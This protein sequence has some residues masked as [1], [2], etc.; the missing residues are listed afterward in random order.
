MAAFRRVLAAEE[1]LAAI[2]PRKRIFFAVERRKLQ[3]STRVEAWVGV[4]VIFLA[5]GFWWRRW[6][7]LPAAVRSVGGVVLGSVVLPRW[8][9]ALTLLGL[10]ADEGEV[11]CT[12]L[13]RTLERCGLKGE[14]LLRK[15]GELRRHGRERRSS[16]L[17][18]KLFT[19]AARSRR[20]A[21]M[22]AISVEMED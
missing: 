16:N 9:F 19:V 10:Q 12:D 13:L 22:V 15:R 18:D 2:D 5:A 11:E 8:C 1:G 6:R 20:L 17:V 21:A 7:R 4:V 14:H 3:T